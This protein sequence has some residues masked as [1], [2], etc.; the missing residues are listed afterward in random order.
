M[1]AEANI[2]SNVSEAGD[3]SSLSEGLSAYLPRQDDIEIRKGQRTRAK[4]A[5]TRFMNSV[6]LLLANPKT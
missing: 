3:L 6:D 4:G 1:M 2:K 5:L